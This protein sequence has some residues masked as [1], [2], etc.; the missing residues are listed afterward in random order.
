M[1]DTRRLVTLWLRETPILKSLMRKCTYIFSRIIVLLLPS[2]VRQ[3]EILRL[4]FKLFYIKTLKVFQLLIF[5]SSFDS[6]SAP[7][8]AVACVWEGLIETQWAGSQGSGLL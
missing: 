2:H 7:I 3:D 6:F 8:K 4:S 1:P 5:D